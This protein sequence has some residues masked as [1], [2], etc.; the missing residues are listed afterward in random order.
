MA[1]Y[2]PATVLEYN[3]GED[4]RQVVLDTILPLVEGLNLYRNEVLVVT[5]PNKKVSAGGIIMP[6]AY[7]KEQRFQG[8]IGLVVGLGE[9]AFQDDDLWPDVDK[10]PAVGTWVFY[11]T[12]DTSECA[13]GG[14]SCR[15]IDDN[16]VRG[17]CPAVD[18][19]R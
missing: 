13:I 17:R 4:P 2:E 6:E 9:I 3:E 10:R 18:S 5:A 16:K 14:Y 12:A 1:V 15:F 7:K 8:K 11:R 19:I